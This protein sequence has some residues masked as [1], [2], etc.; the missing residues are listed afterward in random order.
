MSDSL[1]PCR[2]DRDPD[3]MPLSLDQPLLPPA[4]KTIPMSLIDHPEGNYRFLP[5]IA[6]YSCGVVSSPG[7]EITHVTFQN[8]VPYRAGFQRIE[9]FLA[10]NSRPKAALCG[11]ELR[12]P[13]PFTF[14][15]F[16]AFNAEYAAILKDWGIFVDG[17][18]P[19]ARTN[20]AP[21]VMAPAEPAMYGFS[22]SMPCTRKQPVTFIVAGGGELPE[23]VLN[24]EGII[25]LGDKSE[26]GI[27]TKA[28]FVMDLMETRLRG[29]GADW[30]LVSAINVYTAHSVAPL[31]K[32]TILGRAGTAAIH[33]AVWY[34]SAPPIEEIEFEMDLHGTRTDLRID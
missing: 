22:L 29:L 18:N 14:P 19:V 25:A 2:S 34:Y 21:V 9:Q 6:P 23:G 11:I 15:G 30:S 27:R 8:P 33:G 13:K 16:S 32:E 10:D 7:F 17:V 12:S 1:V 20:V 26:A 31:I 28:E 4:A 5:G 24:R 3:I